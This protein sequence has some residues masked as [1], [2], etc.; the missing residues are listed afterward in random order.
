M[1]IYLG[2]GQYIHSSGQTMGRNGIGID[3]LTDLTDPISAKY[4]QKWWH[5]GRVLKGFDPHTDS[6]TSTTV[7]VDTNLLK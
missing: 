2:E 5:C 3:S 7:D 4:R 1:G 6:L